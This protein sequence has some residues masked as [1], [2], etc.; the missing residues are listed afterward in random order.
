MISQRVNGTGELI[1][2]SKI[3]DDTI[4]SGVIFKTLEINEKT[5]TKIFYFQKTKGGS[6]SREMI[7][8]KYLNPEE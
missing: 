2:T 6:Y 4:V 8:F 3:I 1:F 7:V 5:K